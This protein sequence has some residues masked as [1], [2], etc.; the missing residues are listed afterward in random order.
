MKRVFGLTAD[1]ELPRDIEALRPADRE[2][3]WLRAVGRLSSLS[4]AVPNTGAQHFEGDIELLSLEGRFGGTLRVVAAI[5]VGS[6]HAVTVGGVLLQA[7]FVE[8]DALVDDAGTADALGLVERPAVPGSAPRGP[9]EDVAPPRPPTPASGRGGSPASQPAVAPVAPRAAA[10]AQV[11]AA[12]EELVSRLDDDDE[13]ESDELVRGNVLVHPTL[14]RCRVLQIVGV[15]MVRVQLP[16]RSTP[17]KLMLRPFRV[18][19]T[20]E[21]GC[22]R[23]DKRLNT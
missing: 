10:W 22:F 11:A 19:K 13:I 9:A 5:G 21:A 3:A 7:C 4:I 23:L 18:V 8:G 2:P 16:S 20:D 15:D 6:G 12:S 14:G 17:Q 1:F